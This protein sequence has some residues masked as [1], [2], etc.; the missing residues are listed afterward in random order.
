[1]YIS[2]NLF[3]EFRLT[4]KSQISESGYSRRS[5]ALTIYIHHS[6]SPSAL[7]KFLHF[8]DHP[9]C[10]DIPPGFIYTWYEGSIKVHHSAIASDLCGTGGLHRETIWSIPSFHGGRQYDTVF[11]ELDASKEGLLGMVVA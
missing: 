7:G 1:M 6:G 8:L 9:D 2:P 4:H 11:V 3:T 10:T 5:E